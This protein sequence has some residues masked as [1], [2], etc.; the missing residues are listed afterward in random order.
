MKFF[1]SLL[2]LSL[3]ESTTKIVK[4]EDCHHS[5][6]SFDDDEAFLT[7][8]LNDGAKLYAA[9]GS[10]HEIGLKVFVSEFLEGV[11]VYV[12]YREEFGGTGAN[13][14]HHHHAELV[15]RL[16]PRL[17]RDATS[18]ATFDVTLTLDI[19]GFYLIYKFRSIG[20]IDAHRMIGNRTGP[21]QEYELLI[22]CNKT[23]LNKGTLQ[24]E[25]LHPLRSEKIYYHIQLKSSW[26]SKFYYKKSV[27][28]FE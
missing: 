3:V 10:K 25:V 6:N 5:L 14:R 9:A 16:E 13:H 1:L 26:L 22:K 18:N 19:P 28:N 20:V 4:L 24:L 12:S 23:Q 21:S 11:N 7:V 15:R 17:V 2:V 27:V 8:T